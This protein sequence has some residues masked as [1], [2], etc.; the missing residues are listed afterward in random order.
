M[1]EKPI[2]PSL[3]TL[4]FEKVSL[5]ELEGLLETRETVSESSIKGKIKDS[6]VSMVF[7]DSVRCYPS[8]ELISRQETSLKEKQKYEMNFM[9]QTIWSGEKYESGGKDKV[10]LKFIDR[11]ALNPT[12]CIR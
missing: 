5:N 11:V 2:E 4:D 10:L 6:Y 8:I 12:Q 9:D 1:Q 7:P 3:L